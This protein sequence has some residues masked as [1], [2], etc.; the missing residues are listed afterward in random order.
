LERD[1]VGVAFFDQKLRV[2]LS[3]DFERVGGNRMFLGSATRREYRKDSEN[4]FC[5]TFLKFFPDGR[6]LSH[7]EYN[8]QRTTEVVE[9][10]GDLS[11]HWEPV[12][13][14]GG[15]DGVRRIP[16]GGAISVSAGPCFEE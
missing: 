10:V 12:P 15:Y 7:R 1:F 5:V 11:D 16:R 3:Y 2:Y 8:G 6:V 13:S 4:P 9:T 14:F